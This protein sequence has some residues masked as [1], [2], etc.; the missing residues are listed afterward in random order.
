MKKI[1]SLSFAIL[2]STLVACGAVVDPSSDG[3]SSDS[4]GSGASVDVS[5]LSGTYDVLENTCTGVI[6]DSKFAIKVYSPQ[7]TQSVNGKIFINKA[8]PQSDM[9]EGNQ[10]TINDAGI[11]DQN[12]STYYDC[13]GEFLSNNEA[14]MTCNY[15]NPQDPNV[16][17]TCKIHI[18]R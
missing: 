10:G 4:G 2:L 13:D 14:V 1:I 17:P 6:F 18:K 12:F 15:H 8:N 9:V 7:Q 16:A 11:F 5:Q 3:S